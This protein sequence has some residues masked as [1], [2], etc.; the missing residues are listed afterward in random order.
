MINLKRISFGLLI[1]LTIFSGSLSAQVAP[2]QNAILRYNLDELDGKAATAIPPAETTST[3]KDQPAISTSDILEKLLNKVGKKERKIIDQ[4]LVVGHEKKLFNVNELDKKLSKINTGA[5]VD[6][7]NN[8]KAL[9]IKKFDPGSIDA[10]KSTLTNIDS[11]LRQLKDS[12]AEYGNL[13][14]FAGMTR[15]QLANVAP[16]LAEKRM[17]KASALSNYNDTITNLAKEKDQSSKEKVE[18]A[19][20]RV[21]TIETPF[22]GLVPIAPKKGSSK[23]FITSD[24][25]MRV[26]PVK[27]TRRFHAGV[28]LAGWKCKGWKVFA[29]G[30]GRVVKSGWETGYGYVVIVSHEIEDRQFFS[31]YAHLKKDKRLKNGTIV[32]HG[33]LV[34]YCNNSG[35]STGS[36]LH[37][38]VREESFSGQ[39]L[40]PKDYLPTIAILK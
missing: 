37:F 36:H 15:D 12:P 8:L 3:A 40:D 2:H 29:I 19:K 6:L 26:H 34:G 28:D 17:L 31:R 9:K 32:K 35:I 1:G 24:Y 33:D 27:K 11:A 16:T 13:S 10:I 38:E 30:P 20:E 7:Y 21:V 22:G 5:L 39:T 18:D 14:F 4:I 25:G 23:V